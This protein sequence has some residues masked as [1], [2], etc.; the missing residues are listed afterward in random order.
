[1]ASFP[2]S[3]Y[4][5]PG[6]YTQ[7]LFDNPVQAAVQGVR[8]P[9]WIGTGNEVLTQQD[10]QVVRGSSSSVDQYIPQE[11]ETSRAVVQIT[12]AGQV[13]LGSFDGSRRLLQVR[14]FPIVTGDGSGTTATDAASIEVTI[15]GLPD[16]VLTVQGAIG[17]LELSTAPAAGDEV[18]VSYFFNRTDTL[19]TD[20]VSD[21]VTEDPATIRGLGEEPT[22]GYDITVDNNTLLLTIDSV[23]T[24]IDL[25]TPGVKP[26][27]TVVSIINGQTATTSLTASL[28]TT[29]FGGTAIQFVA[30]QDL[31]VGSG[32]ANTLLGLTAG[33]STNRRKVFFTFQGPIVSGNNGGVTT[34][35]PEKVTATVNGTQVTATAV[36]GSAR[37]VT[38]PYA[39]ATGSTVTIKYYFN[40]WQDTFDYLA[41][42]NVTE[43]IRVGIVPGNS[44]FIQEADF[45]LKDDLIVWGTAV[46]IRSGI[47]TEG[48]TYFGG[49]QGGQ[50]TALLV[51]AQTFLEPATAVTD[52]SVNPPVTSKTV[53]NLP[54]QP[55]TGNGRNTPLGQSLFQ[56]V[57]NNRIDLPTNRPDLVIAY[58]GF[59]VE[60]ALERG[61]VTVTEVEGVQITLQ[62]PVDTG[63]T[64]FATFYYN[65]LVDE[66][67]SLLC[68]VPGA[69]GIGTYFV[70]DSNGIALFTP[71]FGVKGAA[72]TGVTIEFPSGS[73]L[74]PDVR[75][76]S[77]TTGSVEETVTVSFSS[78]DD[79]I[80]KYSVPGPGPYVT[81]EDAS[82]HARFLV[83][84]TALT[85]GAAGIDLSRVDGIDGLGV[86]A[87]LIGDEIVYDATSGKTTYDIVAGSN[88]EVGV[89]MDDV[90]VTSIAVAG[91]GVNAD[92]YVEA[93]NAFSKLPSFTP[94]YTA[95]TRF[96][97]STIITAGEYDDLVF[98]YTG[99]TSGVSGVLTA[100]IAPLTYASPT[101]LA[102]AVQTVVD[103]EIGTLG[104]GFDGLALTVSVDSNSRLRFSLL[105]AEGDVGTFSAGGVLTV[106][107]APVP[108]AG[109]QIVYTSWDGT[110]AVLTATATAT[111][112]GAN[113]FDISSGVVGTIAT[114]IATAVADTTND[115]AEI[116][117]TTGA[118][119]ATVPVVPL[120]PG[121]L[122][123]RVTGAEGSVAG[124]GTFTFVDPSGAVDAAGGYLEFLD[125]GSVGADFSVLS[126]ISTDASTSGEQ[127]KL[128]NCDVARRFTVAGLSGALIYDRLILRNRIVP[129]SGSLSG[130]SQLAQ[131]ELRI[132]GNNAI[133]ETG[134]SP[135]ETGLAA[136]GAVVQP[137][138]LFGEVGFLG[139]Q[140]PTGTFADAR[141]GQPSVTLFADGGTTSQNNI[142]KINVDGTLINVEFT[143]AAG[144]AIPAAGTADVP[145]GPAS[146]A[147]TIITQLRTAAAAVG[148]PAGTF[149][150]EGA[151]IRAVSAT[152]RTSSEVTVGDGNANDILGFQ[153]GGT[154]GRDI[155][156]PE[157]IASALM[158]HHD[159][160][161]SDKYL[162]YAS[163]DATYFA[164]L[165]LASVISDAANAEYLY[166][167]SQA[168]TGGGLGLSSNIT[169]LDPSAGNGSWLLPGTQVNA[170]VGDGASGEEG[171]NGF[172]VTSSDPVDGS[173]S[174]NTSSLN[175]GVGQDGVIDQ[176]YR[177]V[178]TGLV[179]T[180]LAREG[181]GTYPIGV[182]ATFTFEV[183]TKVATDSNL[184]VNTVPG[185]ELLVTNTTGVAVD[186]T[187]IVQTI[188]RGGNEPAVGDLYYV[189]YNFTKDDL[190][191]GL[192]SR[193]SVVERVFGAVSPEFPLSLAAF[194]GMTN[195]AVLVALKQVPKQPNSNQGSEQDYF[196]AI[197]EIA[198]SLPGGAGVSTI[199]LL[200]GDS[201][202]LFNKLKQHVDLQSAIR[203][204]Q[205]RTAING[206]SSGT[207]PSDAGALAQSISDTRMRFVYPDIVALT[208]T[209]AVGVDKQFLVDGTYLASATAG[210]RASPNI[211]VATP[212]TR[213]RLFGF[214]ELRRTLDAVEQ[215]ELAVQ[216]IT[217][218]EDRRPA[219]QIRQGL[220]SDITN[221]VTK[222]PTVITIADAVQQQTRVTLDRFI[223]VKFLPGLLEQIEGRLTFMLKDFVAREIIAAFTGVGAQTTD[224][225]TVV[226]VEAWYQP[227][228][229]LLYII[230]TFNL[231]SSL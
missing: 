149:V 136:L 150:Q 36:N 140:V 212:W 35:D 128:L 89:T 85:G 27:A 34:T 7:T 162:T 143:D 55:T 156:E 51:D 124:A 210:N 216:G 229:P 84:G 226:E 201:A 38:L 161:V 26:A 183:R 154:D 196:D 166:L 191:V 185:I 94:F 106:T 80:A 122:G 214:D 208:L 98:H 135:N 139:G 181:G 152:S 130:V 193:I 88:D 144:A 197:D 146:S 202:A 207:Q 81:V 206:L 33:S 79:T 159:A 97:G 110:Q 221:V 227:V 21:Q 192:F 65:I 70:Q 184:P 2:G 163:P 175:S 224:N 194:L 179:F 64:A 160:T 92:E 19:T 56:S 76:E 15:N 132:E 222:T 18:R 145:L 164:G 230:V 25:G 24:T 211:D 182:G 209:D 75:F 176:T 103:T 153:S 167:Q 61:P 178:K 112:A 72:L 53:F 129:G 46:L 4:A 60:D 66:E 101:L 170:E 203:Q 165:A 107:G 108:T 231:R 11:D 195:G 109:D 6:P 190:S 169:L 50:V 131:T 168:A 40:T 200:R 93:L 186:D 134:L 155:V 91:T 147:N 69:S 173:G 119:A 115:I 58:W 90:L 49:E 180:V 141:D 29:N 218:L 47:H 120:V 45:V 62:D 111:V 113:N 8:I 71:V 41:N 5:P 174:I 9:T 205:E 118:V 172:Y 217:V 63:A 151:G 199:T 223:G 22:G 1:M 30:D 96:V 39:P 78:I 59:S 215:N 104:A 198:G 102:A 73:E 68:D 137:A 189:T 13:I 44:D 12:D 125:A 188:E 86:S 95:Q 16:V 126:G 74:T 42:I 67:Y 31:I 177:D 105:A 23:A 82:D 83:D 133:T 123:N 57:S 43:V 77:G 127:T 213:G 148:L 187:A 121:T 10:L 20:D 171:F 32:T 116:L 220:T 87:S 54:F 3:V 99:V 158:G 114:E 219:I 28:Y 225:P 37:S 100:T 52:T 204:R 228:F 48:A 157:Q 142:F 117:T 138:A 17:V 14:N